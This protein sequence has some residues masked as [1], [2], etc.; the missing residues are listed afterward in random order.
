LGTIADNNQ[1][2]MA[3][4]RHGHQ[5]KTHC[6]RGHAFTADNILWQRGG[7]ARS[8]RTCNRERCAARRAGGA[9]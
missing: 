4:G 6:K 5:N 2:M 7:A 8:C 9:A 1:D 3:K